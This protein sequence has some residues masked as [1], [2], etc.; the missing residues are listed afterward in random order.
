MQTNRKE[1]MG[2]FSWRMSDCEVLELV[3]RIS[4]KTG[5]SK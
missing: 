5:A 2:G 4:E 3:A 1:R